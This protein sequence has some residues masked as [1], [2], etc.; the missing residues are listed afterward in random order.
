MWLDLFHASFEVVLNLHVQV[1]SNL[2][3]Q[4]AIQPLVFI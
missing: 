3:I 1:E 2:V 4:V